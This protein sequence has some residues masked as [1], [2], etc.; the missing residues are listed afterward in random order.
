MSTE[1]EARRTAAAA[2]VADFQRE[3]DAWTHR[4]AGT[5]P[6]MPTWAFRLRD[7]L[8]SLLE[9][10]DPAAAQLPPAQPPDEL[11]VAWPIVAMLVLIAL[12]AG[13]GVLARSVIVDLAVIA[14]IIV[15]TAVV[16]TGWH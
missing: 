9:M 16:V 13:I 14:V 3:V 6:D 8:R 7:Q 5:Q 4:R 11:V 2:V 1:V 12:R 10:P 15:A